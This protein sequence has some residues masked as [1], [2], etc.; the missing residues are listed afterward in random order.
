[1]ATQG[2]GGD[3]KPGL[4]AVPC[5]RESDHAEHRIL[6]SLAPNRRD[7][8]SGRSRCSQASTSGHRSTFGCTPDEDEGATR[9]VALHRG[10]PSCTKADRG[11]ARSDTEVGAPARELLS[12]QRGLESSRVRPDDVLCCIAPAM[13]ERSASSPIPAA[14]VS[15]RF[16]SK[17][18][19]DSLGSG[20]TQRAKAPRTGVAPYR[21]RDA[22]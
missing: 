14:R 16:G 17:G 12:R 18:S 22:K 1:V 9:R 7:R 2:A 5:S 8:P 13:S 20:V 19:R 10:E 6:D 3:S 21:S 15:E 4:T 11:E